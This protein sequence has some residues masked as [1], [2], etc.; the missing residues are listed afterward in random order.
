M[1]QSL[2]AIFTRLS[3][4]PSVRAVV[5]TS[6]GARAFT[7]GL[8]IA[9]ASV[10]GVLAENATPDDPAR[11]ANNIRRHVLDFQACITAVERCEK[12]VIAAMHGIAYGLGLDITLACDVRLAAVNT[13]FAV[14]EVDIALAADIGT[15]TRLPKASVPMSWIKDVCLTARDFGADEALRVGLVSGVFGSKEETV[16]KALEMAQLIASKSPVAVV[17]TKEV[18]NYSRDHSVAEGLNYVAV[19]NAA[20]VQTK[21]IKDAMAARLQRK[22]VKFSKL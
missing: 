20:Y 9:A 15:L 11:T 16:G 19:W 5:L 7:A 8:D 18:I 13:T 6:A 4:D 21:D 22:K 14:K 17:G 2:G 1:W 12:P 10:S 3:N